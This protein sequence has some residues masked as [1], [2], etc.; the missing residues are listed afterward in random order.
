MRH[1]L[2]DVKCRTAKPRPKAYRLG[3]GDGLYLWVSP[4]GAKSWQYRYSHG[5]TEQVATLG[6]YPGTALSEARQAAQQARKNAEAGEHLTA[7]KRVSKAKVQA[8]TRATFGRVSSEWL[9]DENQRQ[10]WSPDYRQEVESS[11]NNHLADLTTL[12][13]AKISAPV[14]ATSLRRVEKKAPD[15]ARK[16]RQRL[17]SILDYAVERG[18]LAGNP[19]PAVRR[20]PKRESAHL[21]AQLTPEAVGQILRAAD[22]AE[23]SK[24]VYRAHLLCAYTAQRIGE[25]VAATWS[26]VDL[27][28]GLW[29]IPRARMKRKDPT[30]GPH[31]VPLPAFLLEQ[32]KA[33]RRIDG[34]DSVFVCPAPRGDGHITR[35]A[36]EKFYRRTLNLGGLHSPH[37]WRSVLSTWGNEAGDDSAVIEAHLDH[38]LGNKV[39][40]AYDRGQ[41]LELRRELADKH[42]MRLEKARATKT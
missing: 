17:R 16:V 37:G 24:G 39:T 18:L 15:M 33:W 4:T 27:E 11:L 28:A 12:P 20:S 41:R 9:D 19:L 34:E 13:I 30:R 31:I 6:S 8:D 35:E 10:R 21:P 29:T 36:V 32:L 3:D 22:K 2:T 25:V 14:C 26:E 42:A 7:L 5:G 23:T 1:K 38:A 40:L